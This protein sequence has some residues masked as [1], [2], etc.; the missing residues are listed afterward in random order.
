MIE[1]RILRYAVYHQRDAFFRPGVMSAAHTRIGAWAHALY[2]MIFLHPAMQ[3]PCGIF[4][5]RGVSYAR[6]YQP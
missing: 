4:S 1:R 2:D 5:Q 6:N 3:A